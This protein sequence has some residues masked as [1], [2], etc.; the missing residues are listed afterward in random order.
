MA[1]RRDVLSGLFFI[2]TLAAWLGYVR[3]GRSVWRYLLAVALFAVGLLAKPM[4]VTLPPLLVLLDFWP[5]GR[6][7]SAGN[8]PGWTQSVERPSVLRLVLEKLPLAALAAA[9]AR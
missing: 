1:E 3:H 2:L 4:L 7:G 6:F 8:R 5:L 9:A